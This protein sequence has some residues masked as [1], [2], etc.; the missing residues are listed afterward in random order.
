MLPCLQGG[1]GV[2]AELIGE[3]ADRIGGVIECERGVVVVVVCQT[4]VNLIGTRK[5]FTI[6][7]YDEYREIATLSPIHSRTP[8]VSGY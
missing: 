4:I 7:E 8:W 2:V 5:A 3:A 6:G 1:H